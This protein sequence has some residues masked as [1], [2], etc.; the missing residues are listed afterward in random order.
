MDRTGPAIGGFPSALVG[1]TRPAA[2]VAG[3]DPLGRRRWTYVR[4]SSVAGASFSVS[5]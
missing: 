4:L 3:G 1:A 2:E 5:G